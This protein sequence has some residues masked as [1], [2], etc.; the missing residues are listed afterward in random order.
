MTTRRFTENIKMLHLEMSIGNLSFKNG[1][2]VAKQDNVL[3]ILFPKALVSN[4]GQDPEVIRNQVSDLSFEC[5]WAE[6]VA[7]YATYPTLVE[8]ARDLCLAQGPYEVIY[9][10]EIELTV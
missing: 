10:D 6:V 1:L 7:N 9:V 8:L 2:P 5:L 4:H 3:M